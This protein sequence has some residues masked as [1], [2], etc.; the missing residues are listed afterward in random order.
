MA[1]TGK[2][3]EDYISATFEELCNSNSEWQL[4]KETN[5]NKILA[6]QLLANPYLFNRT[7]DK[8]QLG[9]EVPN[10]NFTDAP[11]KMGTAQLLRQIPVRYSIYTQVHASSVKFRET[12]IIDFVV[13]D[14]RFA[15]IED[16]V[17]LIDAKNYAEDNDQ[18]PTQ[19]H[20]MLRNLFT[21]GSRKALFV[22]SHNNLKGKALE[23]HQHI[24]KNQKGYG[25]ITN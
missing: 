14:H 5:Y 19:N 21:L 22:H 17:L 25:D 10:I 16:A 4:E 9:R 2:Q 6:T 12:T 7:V 8:T 20:K 3:Y 11:Q 23:Q 13:I 24:S 1:K 15:N 18:I